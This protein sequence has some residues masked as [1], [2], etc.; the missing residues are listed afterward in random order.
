MLALV[1]IIIS[2]TFPVVSV[3][4]QIVCYTSPGCSPRENGVDQST[5]ADCCSHE[6]A[7]FGVSFQRSWS[8][9]CHPCPIGELLMFNQLVAGLYMVMQEY[10]QHYKNS[11]GGL[12]HNA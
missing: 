10:R 11:W 5:E 2:I 1:S 12:L 3:R 6:E 8:E 7:P 9:T 4:A